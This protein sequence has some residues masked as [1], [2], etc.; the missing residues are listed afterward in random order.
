[1][2]IDYRLLD[3][4]AATKG[5]TNA[6][7]WAD[8]LAKRM[9][10]EQI[11]ANNEVGAEDVL[12]RN[13]LLGDAMNVRQN[14]WAEDNRRIA[15]EDRS[16]KMAKDAK[17]ETLEA[18][19]REAEVLGTMASN[20]Q[21]V[22]QDQ[23]VAAVLP[24]FELQAKSWLAQGAKPEQ[25]EQMRQ[26]LAANPEQFLTATAGAANAALQRY[27]LWQQDGSVGTLDRKTGVIDHQ[28]TAPQYK[29]VG[30]NQNLVE[31]GGGGDAPAP[32]T[33]DG[34][35]LD[36]PN[37]K[38]AL[39]ALYPGINITGGD[40]SAER[41]RQVGGAAR[42]HH[43]VPGRAVDFAPIPGKT[44]DD[45]AAD[46]R[47]RGWTVHEALDETKQTNGTGPHWHIAAT[48]PSGGSG[49]ALPSATRTSRVVAE[50]PRTAP[51][52]RAQW[53]NM[54]AEEASAAGLREGGSY[55]INDAGQTRVAQAPASGANANRPAGA[56]PKLPP[57]QEIELAKIR[58]TGRQLA[59][60]AEEYRQW[61]ALNRHVD[62]GGMMA[63]PGAG[64]AAGAVNPQIARMNAIQAKLTPQM[65]QGM[66][67]AASDRD[68]AMFARATVSIGQPRAANEATARA[69]IAFAQ[70]QGDFAAFMDQYARTNGT[71]LGAAEEWSRYANDNPLFRE[72]PNGMLQVNP[73]TPW[74]Q[75][76]NR[77]ANSGGGGATPS[78]PRSGAG[79]RRR[80][81]PATGRIE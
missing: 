23:G 35:K 80:Y 18:E 10:G 78:A 69:G 42:S 37:T 34:P 50:G 1:M 57:Q 63:M 62:T 43:L 2:A 40:R 59:N 55:Q 51:A 41:N 21:A 12:N 31:I 32:S 4:Q 68:V 11:A 65:R 22:L 20:L 52:G 60:T 71:I 3:P 24:A 9:A 74:R 5:I 45:V 17:A 58:D 16:I 19:K 64:I 6:N 27:Q 13:G 14:V 38:A 66:P 75:Y 7:A 8:A 46:L 73:W 15:A 72:G 30:A 81:N 48:P 25:I 53:R 77:P 44:I 61:I 28:Y 47:S 67:G 49:G 54:T 76:F 29:T 39:E 36:A 70:R 56:A 79:T 26:A 33:T